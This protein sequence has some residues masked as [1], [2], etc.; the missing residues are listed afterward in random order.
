MGRKVMRDHWSYERQKRFDHKGRRWHFVRR[1]FGE[2]AGPYEE[3]PYELYF[4]DDA[5]TQFGVL[6]FDSLK[7][8]PYRNHAAIVNKIM[9]NDEFRRS[10]L[11]PETAEV[12]LDSWK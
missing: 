12:W 11:D 9:N 8:N 5:R 7:D 2:E 6:R 3:R 4:R 10:L 1:Y